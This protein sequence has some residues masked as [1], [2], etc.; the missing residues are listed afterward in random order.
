MTGQFLR[1]PSSV[2]QTVLSPVISPPIA[3]RTCRCGAAQGAVP[4][5]SLYLGLDFGTS[6][7][8]AVAINGKLARPTF[9]LWLCVLGN[10]VSSER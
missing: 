9:E 7:A 10:P 2:G 8:R 5:Q 6:G 3:Q 4:S 1:L